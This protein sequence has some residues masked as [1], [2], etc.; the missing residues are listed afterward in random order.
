MAFDDTDDFRWAIE[1]PGDQKVEIVTGIGFQKEHI[2]LRGQ[3]LLGINGIDGTQNSVI[4][5]EHLLSVYVKIH[6]QMRRI[7]KL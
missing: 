2:P 4:D 5:A 6:F 7:V 1:R 3:G